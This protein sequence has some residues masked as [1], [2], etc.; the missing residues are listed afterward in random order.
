MPV[1]HVEL[2]GVLELALAGVEV[3][4]DAPDPY[5]VEADVVARDV[6]VPRAGLG[7]RDRGPLEAEEPAGD[8][9]EPLAH[10]L[11]GEVGAHDL[12]VD[13]VL[14]AAHELGV[15]ARVVGLHGLGARLVLALA[16]QQHRELAARALERCVADA[17]DE[18]GDG[19]ARADHLDLGVVVGPGVVTEQGGGLAPH[20]EEVLEHLVVHRPGDV[21]G[22]QRQLA[23]G[24]AV[25][26]EGHEGHQVG[27]VGGDRDQPVV[28]REVGGAVVVGQPGEPL[29]CE[30]HRA[31]VVADVAAEV[32][33]E[34]H[35]ALAQLAQPLAGGVVAVDARAAEVAQRVVE[36]PAGVGVEGVGLGRRGEVGEDGV[37]VAVQAQLGDVLL[38][39]LAQLVGAVA[40]RGVGVDL[41]PQRDRPGV[42]DGGLGGVPGAQHVS[43][44]GGGLDLRDPAP[45]LVEL[46][47]AARGDPAEPVTRP[48]EVDR[49]GRDMG[50]VGHRASL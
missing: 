23:T 8:V 5:A 27:V 31:H 34:Q 42:A 11:E 13:V 33:R 49:R 10:L 2:R 21:V 3:E 41:G 38:H 29:G 35:A 32:L 12:A 26:A 39:L 6:V 16:L 43:R 48:G 50:V 19:P 45:R 15:V 30:P 47:L 4:V 28:V 14:L 24:R 36:H 7:L 18:V 44:A 25:R 40:D 37:Q 1:D 22:R 9:E 20:R 46:A 17:V